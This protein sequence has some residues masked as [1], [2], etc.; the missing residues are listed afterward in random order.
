M[1]FKDIK[2]CVI[3]APG[4]NCDIETHFALEYFGVDAEIVHINR[5]LKGE[6]ELGPYQ[7]L[8][9]PG[10][11]SF[12]DH[13]RSGAIL[14][15][16]L[17]YKF[18]DLLNRFAE[19]EKP[20]LGICNGFQVLIESGL[21]PG[22]ENHS[23]SI[24]AA[25]GTN[26]SSKFED[27][28]VYLK[29]VGESNC[30]FVSEG[31]GVVRMPVAHGEGRFILSPDN[32]NELLGELEDNGQIVYRYAKADGSLALSLYPDNPNGSVYDIAGI[33]NRSGTVFGL[34]PHP[35]RAFHRIMYPDWTRSGLEKQ[36]D[37]FPIFQNMLK[38]IAKK[39]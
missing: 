33:C 26:V 36:G 31:D 34:M 20:I 10:G 1:D 3:R 29:Q 4:T 39:F 14:G 16:I 25:L 12:G 17:R 6:K 28:W 35:E 2:I 23:T 30:V 38:F 18:G 11:F 32:E 27:R 15:K 21:L 9:I 37:G 19:D 24:D 13:I 5:F 8:V 7:G 22:F